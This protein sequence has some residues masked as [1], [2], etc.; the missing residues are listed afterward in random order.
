M[1]LWEVK[2]NPK[3]ISGT[4]SYV[5]L[6]LAKNSCPEQSDFFETGMTMLGLLTMRSR[7]KRLPS[8]SKTCPNTPK[9]TLGQQASRLDKVVRRT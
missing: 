7:S 6:P 1:L 2:D 9:L 4:A 3:S 5:R 8:A